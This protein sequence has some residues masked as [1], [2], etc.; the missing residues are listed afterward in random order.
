[1]GKITDKISL[2]SK[3]LFEVFFHLTF[4]LMLLS[5]VCPF[6]FGGRELPIFEISYVLLAV[7]FV[8][9]LICDFNLSLPKI[10][11]YYWSIVKKSRAILISL[12]LYISFG[13]V[14]LFY[15]QYKSFAALKYITVIQMIGFC[16]F[17]LYYI[18]PKTDDGKSKNRLNCVFWNLGIVSILVSLIAMI[19]Y[20]TEDYTIYV[21]KLSTIIDY[22]QFSLI[23]TMGLVSLCFLMLRSSAPILQ[24]YLG[25]SAAFAIDAS[26]ILLS[27]SRR[28]Y[29]TIIAFCAIFIVIC[30]VNEISSL[31]KKRSGLKDYIYHLLA[32][33]L[34]VVISFGAVFGIK[35]GFEHIFDKRY[36]AVSE[37]GEP[38]EFVSKDTEPGT[39]V[40]E[41]KIEERMHSISEGNGIYRRIDIWNVVFDKL[42][43]S[44]VKELIIGG[45]ASASFDIYDDITN[46]HVEWVYWSYD[47]DE[48]TPHW[49]NPHNFLLCDIVEGGIVLSVLQL[50]LLIIMF[51]YAVKLIKRKPYYGIFLMILYAVVFVNLFLSAPYG[52]IWNKMFWILLGIHVCE[53]QLWLRDKKAEEK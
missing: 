9:K 5:W 12:I 51:I 47:F 18:F 37:V 45:G 20:I 15:A 14:T 53:N 3:R 30:F 33:V 35:S 2:V 41:Q 22:N 4:G 36:E 24:K 42:K 11:S 39:F 44:S 17:M 31:L 6:K 43:K 21:R 16:V 40:L 34:A 27:S 25:I 10:F 48:L 19:G 28:A 23:I 29:V 26:V 32:L 49:M 1:M 13:V 52:M 8:L 50:T 7:F 46:P 38:T